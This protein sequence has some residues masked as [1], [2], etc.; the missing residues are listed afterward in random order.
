MA[1]SIYTHK[2]LV[3]LA[4]PQKTVAAAR[5]KEENN[6]CFKR[7]IQLEN[8]HYYFDEGRFYIIVISLNRIDK[9]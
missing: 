9:T 4:P 1:I 3:V 6:H 2:I 8:Y 7:G 5:G